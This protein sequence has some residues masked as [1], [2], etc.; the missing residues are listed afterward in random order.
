MLLNS[1]KRKVSDCPERK[2]TSESQPSK[3]PRN[4]VIHN[5]GNRRVRGNSYIINICT[6]DPEQ[7]AAVLRSILPPP[8]RSTEDDKDRH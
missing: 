1:S 5:H 2:E 7:L 3:Q 4:I 8:P 6:P